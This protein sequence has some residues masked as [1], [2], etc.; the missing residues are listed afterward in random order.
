MPGPQAAHAADHQFDPHARLGG[1]VEQ[2]DDRRIHQ[3]IHLG[4]DVAATALAGM[5]SLPADQLFHAAAQ[6]DRGHQQLAEALLLGEAG[7]V[8]E[9]LHQILAEILAGGQQADIGVEVG[10]LGV[11]VAGADVHVAAQLSFSLRTTSR[12]LVWVLRPSTP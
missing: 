2:S 3:G 12:I 5:P 10:G 9:Q 7:E 11:V 1:F 8:I 6:G 4:P